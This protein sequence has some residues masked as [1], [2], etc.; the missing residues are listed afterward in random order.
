MLKNARE[1]IEPDQRCC[2]PI[3]Q[4]EALQQK[5]FR[6]RTSVTLWVRGHR[7][8]PPRTPFCGLWAMIFHMCRTNAA[9]VSCL[10]G[11]IA[12]IFFNTMEDAGAL[13]IEVDVSNL[14]MGDVIDVYPYK[15]EVR[16]HETGE[17]LATFELKTDV[18]IDEV[19]AGGRI[20]L[21]IG[22]G[23]TTKAREA[24]GLPHSDVF[25][26][27]KD[28]AESDRGFSLAQKMVGRACGV[29]GIR[30]G[31]Y[32]EPKMTSVGSQDTTGPMTRDEL[33]DGVHGFSADTVMQS[34]CHTAAYR[35]QL[36]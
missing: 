19:R 4:I 8:N 1:G 31:A 18:L 33:K 13:P 27:A 30:P 11:K 32:C 2:W 35:N 26:Q 25:R 17:L 15:G 16:N 10:G 34:F 6:W 5:G 12:P 29:K 22:R 21:I 24:L 36:T 3:K 7:V 14:N 9:V 23:L 20:P 28:V